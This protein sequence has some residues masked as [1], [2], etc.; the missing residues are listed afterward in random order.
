MSPHPEVCSLFL[1]LPKYELFFRV[2][3]C[4]GSDSCREE[5]LRN[6]PSRK[7]TPD[8]IF[9]EDISWSATHVHTEDDVEIKFRSSCLGLIKENCASRES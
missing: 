8:Y 2:V 5:T 7:N 9:F 4:K 3:T 1:K 6:T